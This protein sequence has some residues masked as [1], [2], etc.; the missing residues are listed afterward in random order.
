MYI[1]RTIF[2]HT[3]SSFHVDWH[4]GKPVV[5]DDG[6]VLFLSTTKTDEKTVTKHLL[7]QYPDRQ[8]KLLDVEEKTVRMSLDDFYLHGEEYVRPQSQRKDN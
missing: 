2:V 1:S 6:N 8:F 4:E 7:N 5:I 3:V